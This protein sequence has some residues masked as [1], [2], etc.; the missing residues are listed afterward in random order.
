VEERVYFWLVL[1]DEESTMAG[2]HDIKQ[3]KQEVERP[4]SQLEA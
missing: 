3:P 2:R 4:L 1:P